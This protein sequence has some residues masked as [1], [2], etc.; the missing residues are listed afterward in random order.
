[1]STAFA[2][3]YQKDNGFRV[4]QNRTKYASKEGGDVT[5]ANEGYDQSE[6][7]GDGVGIGWEPDRNQVGTG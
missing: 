3:H 7:D 2:K 4:H 1:M 6:A 5:T